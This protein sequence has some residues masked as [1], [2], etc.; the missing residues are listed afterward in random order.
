M[1]PPTHQ[2]ILLQEKIS[3]EFLF[4]IKIEYAGFNFLTPQPQEASRP[5]VAASI[6]KKIVNYLVS[7]LRSCQHVKQLSSTFLA[8]FLGVV[9]WFRANLFLIP[10]RLNLNENI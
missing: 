9:G 5:G 6:V 7:P 4:K 8:N 2:K 10:S 1:V 3:L